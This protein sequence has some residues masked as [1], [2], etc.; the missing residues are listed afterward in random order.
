MGGLFLSLLMQTKQLLIIFTLI[1]LVY[2]CASAPKTKP[3]GE[4]SSAPKQAQ[5]KPT[6]SPKYY[7]DKAQRAYAR[8]QDIQLRNQWLLKTAEAYQAENQC[9]QS[10]KIVHLMQPELNDN[11]LTT[12]AN[13]IL[14][15]CLLTRE[16]VD[17]ALFQRLLLKTALQQGF[18]QRINALYSHLYAHK[19]Q[20]VNAAHAMLNSDYEQQYANQQAW[21]FI[22][23][24]TTSEFSVEQLRD[25]I[26]SPLLELHTLVRRFGLSPNELRPAV[27][28]WQRQYSLHPLS[29]NLPDDIAKGLLLWPIQPSTVAVLLPLTG[30]LASQ[31]EAIKEGMLAAFFDTTQAQNS[32]APPQ[33]RFFDSQLMSSAELIDQTASFDLV[34]GPLLKDKLQEISK[35]MP[36]DKPLLALNRID[37][38]ENDALSKDHFFFSLA[39]ED[40]AIQ[41]AH[42]VHLEEAKNP[43]VLAFHSGAP[44]RMA[45]AFISEWESLQDEKSNAPSLATFKDNKSMRDAI[46]QLLDVTQSKNRIKQIERLLS[47]ELHAVPRNRRDI[48]AIIIFAN[49]EQTELLNPI[50]ESSLSPFNDKNVPVFASSRSYSLELNN[51]SLRD[52][53]NLTFTDM[54]WMLPGHKWQELANTTNE[55][56]PNRNDTLRRLFAL[57][58]DSYIIAPYLRQL[59]VFPMLSLPGLTGVLSVNANH[60]VQRLLPYGR[61]ENDKV[62]LVAMD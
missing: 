38:V 16:T 48:D 45:D 33:I 19:R 37:S 50:I 29:Q 6:N 56:W 57:G 36:E 44:K 43:I 18:D 53:R 54:P 31:G 40:E 39:P 27:S 30:R 25:P 49:P 1:W 46:T 15:E 21:R 55:L 60:Q 35:L 41:L 4:S 5:D 59:K 26:L 20:W 32:K 28:D 42:K 17:Y 34:I 11:L 14:A 10:E 12:H 47:K 58:Y 8:T 52:L 7:L 24:V 61:V 2:G 51:N 22:Q 9:V 13:I 3:S 62:S 23:R